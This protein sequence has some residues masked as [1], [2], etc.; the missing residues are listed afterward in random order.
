M[1]WCSY[2]DRHHPL[3]PPEPWFSRHDPADMELPATF[4]D[5][6][7]DWP[8]QLTLVRSLD[9]RNTGGTN[10]V[11]P[12]GPPAGQTLAATAATYGMIEAIDHGIGQIIAKLDELGQADNTIIVFTAD[13]GDMMGDHGLIMKGVM[14]FQGCVRVPVVINAPGRDGQRTTSLAASIDLP[15]TVLDLCRLDEYQGMQGASLVPLLDDPGATVRDSVLIEDDFPGAEVRPGPPVKT[16]TIV[17]HGH[18][19][20][21]DSAGQEVLYD[22][23]NDPDEYT[24]IAVHDR[25]PAAR[26]EL[27]GVL[28]DAMSTADD[29]TRTEPVTL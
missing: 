28:V 17:T 6:G 13:H 14:H 26:A 22:L 9:N 10:S 27:T 7:E 12:C 15:H 21:R 2:P 8:H 24:N 5:P 19:Y 29:L 25:D 11:R 18:R 20:S 16:R 4:D 3:S 1:V 23:M